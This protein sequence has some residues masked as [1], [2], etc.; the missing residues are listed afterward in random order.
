RGPTMIRILAVA[1][2]VTSGEERNT[3]FDLSNNFADLPVDVKTQPELSVSQRGPT[4][5]P[6][7]GAPFDVNV[8]AT[9]SGD[10][11]AIGVVI[12]L[13][14]GNASAFSQWLGYLDDQTVPAMQSKNFT[15]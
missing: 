13:W 14:G 12:A 9:N 8:T 2:G 5:S 4:P 6:F 10:T 3:D 1:E 15:V 7:P 11:D